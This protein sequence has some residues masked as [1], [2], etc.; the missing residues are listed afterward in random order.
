MCALHL[1][2]IVSG[3]QTGVDRAALN[4][5]I[6]L[7]ID[8]GGWCPRGRRA[9]DGRIPNNYQLKET[10]RRDYAIRTE[11]NV[12]D[13][14]GT[15][16]LYRHRTTGG[17][18][19]TRKF[20]LKHS[21]PLLCVDLEAAYLQF[22]DEIADVN[23]TDHDH[24]VIVWLEHHRVATLNIAGPRESTCPGIAEQAQRFLVR[25][26]NRVDFLRG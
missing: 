23:H 11:Q 24:P 5:A 3:G 14:D 22:A 8:H 7:E 12:I 26:L 25:L 2:K 6:S 4:A 1:H 20:A 21:R 16:I 17:T 10:S 18:E 13:S 9:E 15:L 19:L